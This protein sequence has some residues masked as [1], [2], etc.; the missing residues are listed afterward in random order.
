MTAVDFRPIAGVNKQILIPATAAAPKQSEASAIHLRDGKILL[1]W[2]EFLDPDQMPAGERPP[3]SPLRSQASRGD[4]GYARISGMVSADGG[5]TWSEP[6]VVVDDR[7]ALINCMSP[8]LTRLADGRLLLAYSWRSGGNPSPGSHVVS[9][10]AMRRVRFSS[11]EGQSWSEPVQITPADG[12]YHT[13]CHDRA[14]TLPSGR[15]L[16]QCHSRFEQPGPRQS[17][18][19]MTNW[20]AYSDD[21][22]QSWHASTRLT[23]P[24]SPRG[25]AEASLAQRG[26]GS[27]LMVM[28]TTL[29]HSFFTESTDEGA[30]W[31]TPYPSGVVTSAAPSL[32]ARLPNSD[33]LLLVWNPNYNPD[34]GGLYGWRCPLL[35]AVSRD[36]GRSWGLPKALE[37]NCAFW[38]EYPGI[39]FDGDTAL[40]HYR[41]FPGDRSCCHLALAHI[42]IAWFYAD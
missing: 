19:V 33:D 5:Y 17:W 13:G 26:D 42:P 41:V 6:W 15:V 25:F 4:D 20:I 7:D 37:T 14:W 2:T 34:Q 30:T 23:E 10:A 40:L 38:W 11:D 39:L 28:R 24:R 21:N 9:G 16:V 8:A 31:S 35:C 22:G 1:V 18:R 32:L 29:G 12:S 27:L 3:E 36:G